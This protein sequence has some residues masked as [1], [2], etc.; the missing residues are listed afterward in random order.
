MCRELNSETSQPVVVIQLP[1][2][3]EG[4][5]NPPQPPA[6]AKPDEHVPPLEVPS[7][8]EMP[9][10]IPEKSRKRYKSYPILVKHGPKTV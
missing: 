6:P 9:R 7:P 5:E 1:D 8:E 3:S 10:P 2:R 4:I